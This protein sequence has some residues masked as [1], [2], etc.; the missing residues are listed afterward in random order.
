MTLG[1]RKTS[2]CRGDELRKPAISLGI[3]LTIALGIGAMTAS[4]VS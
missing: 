1:F 3:L 2:V 4:L